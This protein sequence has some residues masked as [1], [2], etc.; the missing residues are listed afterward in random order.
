M[1]G[2]LGVKNGAAAVRLCSDCQIDP[3]AA[4]KALLIAARQKAP[5]LASLAG[6][7]VVKL[8]GKGSTGAA[9]LARRPDTGREL[10]LKVLLPRIAA[11]K[12]ARGSFLREV[13]NTKVLQHPNVVRLFDSGGY[14]GLFFYTMEYCNKGGL[15]HLRDKHGG[16]LPLRQATAIIFQIL[17]GLDYIH[18]AEI[19]KVQLADG[20]FGRG[21]GLVHR[22]L[23]PANIFLHQSGGKV[24]A[25]IAD[26]GV[27]KA[28]DTAGLSG[29]TMTGSVAGSP[30]VMPRQ[31]VINFK[32][33][34]PDV[35]V[36]AAAAT[37]YNLLT[38]RFPRDFTS[39][40]DP[41]RVVLE[42][43]AVPIRERNPDV[44][45]A[46]ARVI[47]LALIDNPSIT[48]TRAADLKRALAAALK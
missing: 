21:R 9:Y 41:W 46:L 28:F 8:L 40:L 1:A 12:W 26:V 7:K 32:Y 45:P 30:V 39:D 22:D 10:A 42:Q 5:G 18:Q 16:R 24:T 23:K 47:D 35:D 34:K 29:Q 43:P 36:W 14:G 27:G 37:Y 20:R 17:D 13:D 6:L 4:L 11:N 33:A 19:P 2:P 31:Q 15:D 3:T 44:P 48:Y 38:G 25:K